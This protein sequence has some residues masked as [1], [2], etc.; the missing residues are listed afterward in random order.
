MLK[1]TPLYEQH[2]AS[3]ARFVEFSGW[4]M[5]I[6]YGSQL[7]EQKAVREHLG[8]FDVSHMAVVDLIG[9]GGRRCLRHLLANDV[10][11]LHHAG[12]A[13]YSTMLNHRGGIIEDLIVY[14]LNPDRYRLVLNAS[15]RER[16]LAWIH[17]QTNGTALGLQER[18]EFAMMAVQGPEAIKKTC[19]CLSAEKM[20][21][22]TTLAPFESVDI[23]DC[24][25]ARTGYTGEDGLEIIAPIKK[26]QQLWA[27]L[28]AL[29]AAPCGLGARDTLRL[30]AGLLLNGQDMDDTTSPLE[31]GLAWTIAW[32]PDDRDFIGRAA[33]QLQKE[34]GIKRKLVGLILKDKGMLRH[35]QTVQFENDSQGI[36][37]S[38]GFS[39]MIGSAIALALVPTD[40]TGDAHVLARGREL[41][42][43]VVKP[44]FV[45]H[46]K[47]LPQ[48]S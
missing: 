46:G 43:D 41:K 42:V 48:T 27:E 47:V 31:C 26:I 8:L 9:A 16:D 34:Q 30:E 45:K 13:L 1:R 33:L 3:G 6:N 15:T 12:S 36:I 23:D 38:G 11:R 37:T 20:D 32:E 5:P 17:E 39:P 35:G 40:A 25:F 24:F 2:V 19:E 7:A 4:E 44:R 22:V 18:T 10:D 29:G 14:M 21:A 28:L